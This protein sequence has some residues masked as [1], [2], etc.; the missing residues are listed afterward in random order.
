M[1]KESVQARVVER[2]GTTVEKEEELGGKE[3]PYGNYYG[4]SSRKV[5]VRGR[6]Q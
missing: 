5:V 6:R 1:L 3:T 4:W 2:N